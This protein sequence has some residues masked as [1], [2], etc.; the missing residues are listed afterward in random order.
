MTKSTPGRGPAKTRLAGIDAARG[1]ALLGMMATHIIPLS[2]DVTDDSAGAA[3]AAAEPTWA[4]L[5]FAGKASALFAVLAGV[6]LALLT[7][8]ARPLSGDRLAATRRGVVVRALAIATLGLVGGSLD[9]HVAVI[10]VHYGLLFLFAIPFLG[11]PARRL[12]WWAGGWLLLSPGLLFLARPPVSAALTPADVGGSP[13]F[14]DLFRPATLAADLLVTGYYPVLVWTGFVLLGLFVGRCDVSRPPVAL[15]FATAGAAVAAGARALSVALLA[16][17]DA[18]AALTSGTGRG[19]DALGVS[20]RTGQ[21]LAGVESTPWWFALSAPHTGAP[22][23]ILH[24]AGTAVAVLGICQLA[25]T[26]LKSLLGGAGE[27]LLWPIAGAGAATLTLY[28]GHLVGLDLLSGATA[29]RPRLGV[30]LWY[31]GAALL[32][33]IALKWAAVRGPLESMVHTMAAGAAGD[34]ARR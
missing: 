10:L 7:G 23:D 22:L 15:A 33:G 12:A 4:A 25:A 18:E 6:G 32:V 26:A 31:A 24:V 30:Y 21:G 9:T 17:P 20:L 3:L 11:L 27:M 5:W 14:M 28:L 2:K 13:V 8:A 34:T 1:L 19:S 16:R 29:D